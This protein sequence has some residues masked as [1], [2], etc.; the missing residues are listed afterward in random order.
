MK[1][2]IITQPLRTNYG[3]LL[4]AYALQTVLESNGHQVEILDPPYK[5]SLPLWKYPL[6]LVKR[7]LLRYVFQRDVIVL[8]ENKSNREYPII[9]QYTKRFIQNYIKRVEIKNYNKLEGSAYDVLIA[10]SD[11]VWRPKYN[12][13]IYNSFFSFAEKWNVKRIA[14]AASFGTD[15]WEFTPKQTKRCARLAKRFDLITTREDSGVELCKKYLGISAY[16]VLDPTLLL[17]RT[18][19]DALVSK[20]YVHPCAGNL[21]TYIL[22]ESPEIQSVIEQVAIT[23][24]L[25]P[26]RANSRVE[27]KTAPIGERIQP[28]VEQ[29][30]YGFQNADFVI[31]DSFH[32]CVFSIIY[33]VPF[34]VLGNNQRGQARFY[35]LLKMFGLE[36]RFISTAEQVI[37]LGNIDW[38]KV[39]ERKRELGEKSVELL[40]RAICGRDAGGNPV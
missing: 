38:T 8:A 20:G 28:S 32:A 25:R 17:E 7:L 24:K 4:Q 29:W 16:H 21:M 37:N 13:N 34:A 14:Y 2:G 5:L 31:T 33:N 19:Y 26:F 10:G 9:S 18:D 36:D 27:N 40:L 1:I 22:D 15:E 23:I 3:G 35:S 11:Q 12:Q 30:L 6:S 39:N